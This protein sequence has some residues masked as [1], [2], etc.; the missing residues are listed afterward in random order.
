MN[1]YL[2]DNLKKFTKLIIIKKYF[3]ILIKFQLIIKELKIFF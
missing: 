1:K 3:K 2:K